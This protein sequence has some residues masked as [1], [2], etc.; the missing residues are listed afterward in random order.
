VWRVVT[1]RN[2]LS[3]CLRLRLLRLIHDNA[4]NQRLIIRGIKMSDGAY[5]H[6]AS[7]FPYVFLGQH[8]KETI[9]EVPI[10][11]TGRCSICK[12]WFRHC[13]PEFAR[14]TTSGLTKLC[15]DNPDPSAKTYPAGQ[16]LIGLCFFC[17][18]AT[19]ISAV[20]HRVPRLRTLALNVRFRCTYP[21][22][23]A[24]STPKLYFDLSPQRC[25]IGVQLRCWR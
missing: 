4:K 24:I 2:R 15:R 22:Y 19:P 20:N 12:W 17:P 9:L 5:A 18:H 7:F 8:L 16:L 25:G 21:E 14:S 23:A 3:D 10:T 6:C 11:A 1:A 13:L